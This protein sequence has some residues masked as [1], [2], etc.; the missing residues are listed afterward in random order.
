MSRSYLMTRKQRIPSRCLFSQ[1]LSLSSTASQQRHPNPQNNS[2][3]S[4]LTLKRGLE[5]KNRLVEQTPKPLRRPG[6]Q[7]EYQHSHPSRASSSRATLCEGSWHGKYHQVPRAVPCISTHRYNKHTRR[8][9]LTVRFFVSGIMTHIMP[10]WTAHHTM[11]T[12]Y[13]FHLIFSKATGNPNWLIRV[14][15]SS[16]H[17]QSYKDH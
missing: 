10:D 16:Q 3:T 9:G 17:S 8:R 5:P 14:P 1:I 13:V 11:N 6:R 15:V 12:K 4:H 7:Q 2:K